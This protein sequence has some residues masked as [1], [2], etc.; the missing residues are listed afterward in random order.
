MEG[1]LVL[2][3]QSGAI[4]A[5]IFVRKGRKGRKETEGKVGCA[6]IRRAMHP[7]LVGIAFLCVLCG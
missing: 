4:V 5:F 1:C 2:P 6:V 3:L 7:V